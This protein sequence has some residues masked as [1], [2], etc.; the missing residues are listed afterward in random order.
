MECKTP[1]NRKFM[2]ENFTAT[3]LTKTYKK[4]REDVLLER[5]MGMMQA[6][7]PKVE[8]IIKLE[9]IDACIQGLIEQL[10]N[11]RVERCSIEYSVKQE[12]REFVRKCPNS[13]CKGFLS[14]SLKCA[15]CET[16]ACS[17]CREVKGRTI[18]ERDSHTCNPEIV[19][20]V[21]FME[22]DAKPCPK[23]SSMISKVDGC[24]GK[25]VPILMW[26]GTIKMSQDIVVGDILIGDDGEQRIVQRLMRG[27]DNLFKV[28][29]SNGDDYIASSHHTLVLI[30]FCHIN[31]VEI[32]I[33]EYISIRCETLGYPIDGVNC[34]L[35]GYSYNCKNRSHISV[36]SV[37][38]G[39]YYGWEVDRNHRFLGADGTVY[40]NC[41][42]MFCVECHTAFSW[43]TLQIQTGTIHNPHYFQY[44]RNNQQLDRNPLDI[45]CGRELDHIFLN[46]IFLY[47]IQI[48]EICREVIH[49]RLVVIPKFRIDILALNEHTRIQYLQ[50]RIDEDTLKHRVQKRDKATKKNG[51]LL[52][53]ATMYITA[54]TDIFYRLRAN[55]V[56]YTEP[57]RRLTEFGSESIIEITAPSRPTG[58]RS[59]RHMPL[60]DFLAEFEGLR[61]YVNTE[62]QIVSNV[63]KSKLWSIDEYFCFA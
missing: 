33:R 12:K 43:K 53:I 45:Q 29:Q 54:M 28:N 51:E 20:N 59:I 13:E 62:L 2:Y 47:P 19:K 31:P 46:S 5:E 24:F 4:H 25:D 27:T 50:N 57:R 36:T 23:C 32:T 61:K 15:L 7:Q 3:F 11:L 41:D 1:W 8:K 39:D 6:T 48:Q 16:F 14:S 38:N 52:N 21:E 63:Y 56:D 58:K 35:Y 30:P 44:M 22:K 9:N 55:G 49:T 42:Q 37:G 18:E 26:D 60:E 40:R 34:E 10:N 17:K